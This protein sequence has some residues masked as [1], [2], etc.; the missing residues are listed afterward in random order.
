MDDTLD[1]QHP[2]SEEEFSVNYKAA[3]PVLQR[4]D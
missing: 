2:I 3:D 4:H 1:L